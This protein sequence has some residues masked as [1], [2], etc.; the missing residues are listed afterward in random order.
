MMVAWSW[1]HL[2]G[3]YAFATCFFCLG[4]ILIRTAANLSNAVAASLAAWLSFDLFVLAAV[5]I[6]QM[7]T[8]FG[9]TRRG[10]MRPIPAI[11]MMPFLLTA[12]T[13][14]W[15]Q[16]SLLREPPWHEVAPGT[17]VGRRCR[18]AEFP[19]NTSTVIDCTAEFPTNRAAR[20]SLR[21]LSI[22]V[23]DGCAPTWKDCLAACDFVEEAANSA[24]FVY[25]A[26]GHGRSVTVAAV[27][28][29]RRGLSRTP[30]AAVEAITRCRPKAS[31][32]VEQWKFLEEA[33]RRMVSF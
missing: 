6:F 9:K 24:V 12:W 5:Y 32:N 33:S 21:W 1:P 8:V 20:R 29:I 11:L 27:L 18:P 4:L 31:L 28:L 3:R 13:V 10:S 16:K 2:R 26:N 22:P 15:L 19:P 7:P 23:L 30:Q 17:F 25:C 14:W